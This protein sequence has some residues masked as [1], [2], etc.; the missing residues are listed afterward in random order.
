M[1]GREGGRGRAWA[2]TQQTRV[3]RSIGIVSFN[4]FELCARAVH[5]ERTAAARE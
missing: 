5:A 1:G 4:I 3:T 2:D